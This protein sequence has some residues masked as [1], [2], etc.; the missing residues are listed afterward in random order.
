MPKKYDAQGRLVTPLDSLNADLN[1]AAANKASQL[2]TQ[3]VEF[4]FKKFRL[5]SA[6]KTALYRARFSLG[7]RRCLLLEDFYAQY[8]SFPIRLVVKQYKNSGISRLSS[9]FLSFGSQPFVKDLEKL[10]EDAS[11]PVQGLVHSWPFI[12]QG[13]VLHN[14]PAES[15]VVGGRFCYTREDG[16]IWFWEPLLNLFSS[17]SWLPG[18]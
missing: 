15:S 13:M 16:S 12:P 3:T 6:V 2:E 18:E 10:L 7:E 4:L 1:A 5:P 9:L 14:Y 17:I 11:H 8:P